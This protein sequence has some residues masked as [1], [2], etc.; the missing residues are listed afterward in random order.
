MWTCESYCSCC[1]QNRR[2]PLLCFGRNAPHRSIGKKLHTDFFSRLSFCSVDELKNACWCSSAALA[3]K[4]PN[5]FSIES[6]PDNQNPAY[7][8]NSLNL[9]CSLSKPALQIRTFFVCCAN[10][11]QEANGTIWEHHLNSITL[12][13]Q[14]LISI[15]E[16]DFQDQELSSPGTSLI[17][18]VRISYLSVLAPGFATDSWPKSPLQ[19]GIMRR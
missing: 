12:F 16:V 1:K 14:E 17:G 8:Q 2:Q 10:L 13:W 18:W 3:V 7:Q 19:T 11:I 15:A 5:I 6:Q 9:G 4:Q